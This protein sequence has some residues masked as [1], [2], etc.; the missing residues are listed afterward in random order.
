MKIKKILVANRGEIAIRI[1]RACNEIN[2]QTVAIY[3]FE[4]RYSQHRYKA[5]EAYQVGRDDDPLKPYLDMDSIIRIA[6]KV[7]A[8]A[9]H[10]GY[11]FLSENSQFARKCEEN[12]IVFIGPA[13]DVMDKL[14]NKI[15]GKKVAAKCGVPIIESSRIKLKSSNEALEEAKRIGF[16]VILKAAAGGRGQRHA[17]NAIQRG[18][19]K[20]F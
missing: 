7:N 17:G 10:P 13:P 3:T 16:P 12:N 18:Y 1:F 6:R 4:D 11:G 2:I 5:D 15:K 19:S 14:G 8:D 20:R 9:I